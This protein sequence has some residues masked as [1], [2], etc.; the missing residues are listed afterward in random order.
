M[1][2]YFGCN[3]NNIQHQR[4]LVRGNLSCVLTS[5]GTLKTKIFVSGGLNKC[6]LVFCFVSLG[7][8]GF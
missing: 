1:S 6:L 7:F 8:L 3:F 5:L 2:Y 4:K